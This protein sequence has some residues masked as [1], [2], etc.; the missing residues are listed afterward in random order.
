MPA[1]RRVL[2]GCWATL[3]VA[4]LAGAG[5]LEWLGPPE[6]SAKTEAA[7]AAPARPVN[8][9]VRQPTAAPAPEVIH[10]QAPSS[11]PM[12]AG[13]DEPGPIPSPDPALLA[14][15]A[16]Q[17]GLMLPRIAADGRMPMQVYARGYDRTSLRPRVAILLAGVGLNEQDSAD[18]IRTLPGQISLAVS[19]YAAHPARLLD[20]ARIAEHE[21]LISLP[22]EPQG[23][24][25]NDAG[26]HALLAGAPEAE[27]L[28]R[29]DWALSRV[30]GYVGA[31]GALGTLRGERFAQVTRQMEDVLG[32]IAGRGL[33]YVDPRPG[34]P[35][36]PLVWGRTVDVV[37]D[38]P[39]TRT[40]IEAKLA[41]LEQIAHDRG[42]AL[43]LA[44]AVRPVTVDRLAAWTN[45]LAARGLALAPVSALMQ[46]P[47]D[48]APRQGAAL[49][50][51]PGAPR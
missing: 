30:Q 47:P 20:Q 2:L 19:P 48:P 34:Q 38:E 43:G 17:P 45:G 39:A 36:P 15:L 33:L 4:A 51:S 5:L 12:L 28:K 32:V 7:A 29:L 3:I 16:D 1:H 41:Q 26:D 42:S 9:A 14:P 13:R 49:G 37:I 22:L 21:Y 46:A 35:P 23:Y 27:N 40:E 11:R 50:S 25:L 31:T 44:G 10:P 24:P 18:A 6:A 8:P